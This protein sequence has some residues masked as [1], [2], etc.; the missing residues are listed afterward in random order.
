[1]SIYKVRLPDTYDAYH[2]RMPDTYVSYNAL[3]PESLVVGLITIDMTG[4]PDGASWTLSNS[5]PEDV[6]T[7]SASQGP[8]EYPV[9]TYVLT[10][11]DTAFAW[12]PPAASEP[13]VLASGSPITFG[14]P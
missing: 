1:M 8:T 7:G 9:E 3:I 6:D 13:T 5:V 2:V 10:W 11:E 14:P 12:I 4:R